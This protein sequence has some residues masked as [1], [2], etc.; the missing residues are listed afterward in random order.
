[1]LRAG[2]IVWAPWVSLLVAVLLAPSSREM[3]LREA[4]LTDEVLVRSQREFQNRIPVT[5]KES[6]AWVGRCA[7]CS[8]FS[9]LAWLP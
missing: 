2:V 3:T 5:P 4:F 8:F 9:A 6:A 1:M 7:F